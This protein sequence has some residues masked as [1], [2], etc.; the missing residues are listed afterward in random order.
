MPG[1]HIPP[2][3]QIDFVEPSGTWMRFTN[4]GILNGGVD[5]VE[6]LANGVLVIKWIAESPA[7]WVTYYCCKFV[8][9]NLQ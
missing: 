8:L 4:I 5:D 6:V 9:R 3:I 1:G 7:T 2:T